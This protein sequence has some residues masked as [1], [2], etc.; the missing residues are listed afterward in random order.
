MSSWRTR[1]REKRQP[2]LLLGLEYPTSPIPHPQLGAWVEAAQRRLR[3]GEVLVDF[4]SVNDMAVLDRSPGTP[5]GEG[6]F[7]VTNIRSMVAMPVGSDAWSGDI[8]H[9]A[10]SRIAVERVW[11]EPDTGVTYPESGAPNAEAIR[12]MEQASDVVEMAI[13]QIQHEASSPTESNYIVGTAAGANWVVLV[14]RFK[15]DPTIPAGWE[16][17]VIRTKR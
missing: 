2:W 10:V 1:R 9:D 4:G 17:T 6:Y 14:E 13:V 12:A 16:P 3:T 8:P 5:R 15:D 7:A 11:A